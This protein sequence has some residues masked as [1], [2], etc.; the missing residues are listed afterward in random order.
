[1]VTIINGRYSFVK[2]ESINFTKLTYAQKRFG[3]FIG[4]I[5]TMIK[6]DT[7]LDSPTMSF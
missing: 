6:E 1:M 3:S 2:K 7:Q 4:M 5:F